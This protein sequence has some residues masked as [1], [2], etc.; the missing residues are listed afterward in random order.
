M[1]RENLDE[2]KALLDLEEPAQLGA[3]IQARGI[4]PTRAYNL[5]KEAVLVYTKALVR[6]LLDRQIRVNSV[7]PAPVAT[8]LERFRVL[9]EELD[10]L[11]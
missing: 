2:V 1:W 9:T 10:Q 7:S 8:T 6:P 5:S 4:D 11:L 3:F